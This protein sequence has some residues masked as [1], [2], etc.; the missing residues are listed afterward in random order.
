[1]TK[2]GC[3]GPLGADPRVWST[4]C[5]N[6]SGHSFAPSFQRV[7]LKQLTDDSH[8]THHAIGA[9]RTTCAETAKIPEFVPLTFMCL[10]VLKTPNNR[11]G[12]ETVLSGKKQRSHI[13]SSHYLIGVVQQKVHHAPNTPDLS[14][15]SP[16]LQASTSSL[17]F[18]GLLLA[19][20]RRRM[21]NDRFTDY[22]PTIGTYR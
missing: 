17:N 19:L 2:R 22:P 4:G 10:G 18:N 15:F 13:H 12:R 6:C 21:T 3:S 1:V 14:A 7:R 5:K 20:I 16:I 11:Q 9:E 8:D